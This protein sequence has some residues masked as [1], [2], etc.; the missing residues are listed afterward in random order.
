MVTQDGVL[1]QVLRL[2]P[3]D[4]QLEPR[5]ILIFIEIVKQQHLHRVHQW[6]P[7]CLGIGT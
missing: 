4:K 7:L 3:A 1:I 2:K 5:H 6:G